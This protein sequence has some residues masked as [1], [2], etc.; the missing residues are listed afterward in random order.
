MA[1]PSPMALLNAE[2]DKSN[3][4][5]WW[6]WSLTSDHVAQN[7]ETNCSFVSCAMFCK[8]CVSCE[9]YRA[10]LCWNST[11]H[12]MSIASS[13]SKS[14]SWLSMLLD[15]SSIWRM[16]LI[17]SPGVMLLRFIFRHWRKNHW[18]LYS[19][20]GMMVGILF[21]HCQ[22]HVPLPL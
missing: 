6:I 20:Q 15:S 8:F 21:G 16:Q 9:Q 14:Q 18:I 10:F 2:S 13:K 11:V 4:C 7:G 17:E 22:P 1:A 12:Q 19:W 5:N 3:A